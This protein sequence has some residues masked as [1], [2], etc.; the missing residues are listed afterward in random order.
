MLV[1][2]QN[3]GKVTLEPEGKESADDQ[4]V[5]P[6]TAC[7]S[8]G[9]STSQKG[10][11]VQVTATQGDALR[12]KG[13]EHCVLYQALATSAKGGGIKDGPSSSE[14]R[15]NTTSEGV[16]NN[17]MIKD[18]IIEGTNNRIKGINLS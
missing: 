13:A 16:T 15:V 10:L 17:Y 5:R 18:H 7:G 1:L 12:L 2:E 3:M 9:V 8:E 11:P 6:C 4:D 14:Y